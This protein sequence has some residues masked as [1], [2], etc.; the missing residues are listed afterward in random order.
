MPGQGSKVSVIIPTRNSAKTLEL[1]IKSVLSQTYKNIELL[2]IDNHSTD[3]TELIA[4][5]FNDVCFFTM[6]PERSA[7]R[8]YGAM[9]STGEYYIFLD[10]DIELSNS[11]VEECIQL[12][13]RGSNVIT[14]P[15]YIIGHG[16][17]AQCR[18]LEAHCYLGDDT[19]E[20][21]RFYYSNVF[22]K[23]GGFDENL[24]GQEDWDLRDK[25]IRKGYK[26]S[27]IKSR[28]MHHEGKITP[29]IRIRRKYY[30]GKTLKR[31]VKKYEKK[32]SLNKIPFLRSCYYNQ[33]RLLISYPHYTLGFIYLK[34]IET[35]ATGLGVVISL[36]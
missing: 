6:G 26:I 5:K 34:M 21:P 33:W 13:E 18:A 23:V 1:V 17:W 12:T 22:L 24:T 11:V 3:A 4:R 20:A 25:V 7:Q 32:N 35:I 10:S 14:F 30:Y 31:Y 15:E 19:I 8:N 27:R 29:S 36:L 28:T 9:L 2:I 16:F